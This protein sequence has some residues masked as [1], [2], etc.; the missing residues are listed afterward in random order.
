MVLSIGAV[1][2]MLMIYAYRDASQSMVV[3]SGVQQRSDYL[4]KE[5]AALRS[6]LA[7]VPDRAI[8]AMQSGSAATADN[9]APLAWPAIFQEALIQANAGTSVSADVARTGVLDTT[10]SGNTGDSVIDHVGLVFQPINPDGNL[11]SSGCTDLGANFPPALDADAATLALDRTYPIISSSK[12]YG[13]QAQGRVGLPVAGYPQYNL[14]PYPN[15]DFGYGIPGQNFVAKR[16]WWAFSVNLYYHDNW[17]GA[18]INQSRDYV[19]SIYEI[20]SQLS[21][22]SNAFTSIGQHASGA[23]WQNINVVGGVY[24]SRAQVEGS[25]E[26]SRLSSRRGMTLNEAARI[27]DQQFAANPFQPGIREAYEITTGQF[28]PVSLSSETGRAAF[29]PINRGLDFYDRYAHGAE[30]LTLSPTTWNNY[31]VGALQ[32]AMKLDVTQVVSATDQTPTQVRFTCRSGGGEVSTNEPLP[33][34]NPNLPF[35]VV[36]LSNSRPCLVIKPEL[37]S[38]YLSAIGGDP[39]S[40]N[41]SIA[42]NADYRTSATI[43]QPAYPCVDEDIGLVM[44]NCADLSAFSTGFSLVTNFR[45]YIADHFNIV[46]TTAPAGVAGTFYPPTSLYAPERRFG[47]DKNPTTV[48][49]DGT[50]GSLASDDRDAPVRPLDLKNS[51]GV[52]FASNRITVNLSP[53]THPGALP[54]ITMMNWL[55]VLEEKRG[56]FYTN[57]VN[58]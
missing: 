9:S 28:Y 14:I 54:P 8:R 50:V 10:Y 21:I 11:V 29:V 42:V 5:D 37:L 17:Q 58:P 47:S 18:A 1:L 41:N 48:R 22:S 24:A 6:L 31:S 34:S 56:E 33:S 43:R 3:A 38:A 2:T 57:A 30:A 46:A 19:L 53:I 7:I 25:T 49:Q 52:E 40:V 16:N 15:I 44:K 36:V 39:V 23:A 13:V 27:G 45:L 35:D 32:C 51:T 4:N 12:F 26:L 55:I 20:P